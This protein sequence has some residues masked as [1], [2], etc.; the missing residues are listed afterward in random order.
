[1]LLLGMRVATQFTLARHICT[2]YAEASWNLPNLFQ[3]IILES[4][5]DRKLSEILIF[6]RQ[7][8]DTAHLNFQIK[9]ETS[10]VS[11]GIKHT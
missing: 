5:K 4:H 11:M 2:L 9:Y 8:G 1:M 3:A 6:S 7:V 10:T